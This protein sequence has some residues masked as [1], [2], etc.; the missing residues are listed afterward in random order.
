[1]SYGGYAEFVGKELVAALWALGLLQPTKLLQN[2]WRQPN[3]MRLRAG[4][5]SKIKLSSRVEEGYN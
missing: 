3:M 1:M 5:N 2:Q 4:V